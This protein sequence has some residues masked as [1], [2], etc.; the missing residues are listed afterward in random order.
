M[1]TACLHAKVRK[2][3]VIRT[4]IFSYLNID[5]LPERVS[6]G[7]SVFYC[8]VALADAAVWAS[9]PNSFILRHS[10]VRLICRAAAASL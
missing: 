5:G 7:Q 3:E 10:V 9:I 6:A 4:F 8:Y 2:H 1:Q